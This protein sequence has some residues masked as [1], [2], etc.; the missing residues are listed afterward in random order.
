MEDLQSRQVIAIWWAITWRSQLVGFFGGVSAG[1][2]IGFAGG[3]FAVDQSFLTPLEIT[4]GGLAWVIA[5]LWAVREALR[6]KYKG[7]R[8]VFVPPDVDVF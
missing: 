5:S 1:F 3:L 2:V 6:K 8:L 4:A 7:F